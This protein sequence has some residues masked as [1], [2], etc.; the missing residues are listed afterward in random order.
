ME[1]QNKQP[2]F[3]AYCHDE[4]HSDEDYDIEGSE[5]FHVECLEQKNTYYDPIDDEE[6][7]ETEQ[8]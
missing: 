4:I 8:E 1:R 5:V 3:C 6:A 2:I 7:D